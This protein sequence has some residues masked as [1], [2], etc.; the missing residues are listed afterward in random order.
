MN[1]KKNLLLST[2]TIVLALSLLMVIIP[3]AGAENGYMPAPDVEIDEISFSDDEPLEG[4]EITISI[5]I[6][7][8]EELMDVGNITLVLYIDYEEIENI[9]DI[10]LEAN[11]SEIFEISWETESGT[12]N[13]TAMLMLDGM[14]V[15]ENYE[16]LEVILGDVYTLIFAIIFIIVVVGG[17]ILLPSI[18]GKMKK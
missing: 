13:V 1:I 14:P 5:T 9:T 18:F 16:E 6:S 11:E 17:T 10:D 2:V 15:T 3:S 7:N 8:N 4:D 12:H